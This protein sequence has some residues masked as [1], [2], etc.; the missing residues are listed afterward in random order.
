M[1]QAITIHDV[2]DANAR[3]LVAEARRRV[4]SV[5]TVAGHRLLR[6]LEWESRRAEP[7]SYHGLD[8]LAGTWSE[9][10]ATAFF[11]AVAGSE[12]LDQSLWP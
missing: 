1:P 10:E 4:V 12:C 7:P 6:G 9:E 5:E 3:W 2:D 11:Q 8:A